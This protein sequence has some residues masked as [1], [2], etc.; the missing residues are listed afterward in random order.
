MLSKPKPLI[1]IVTPVYNGERFLRECVESVLA[2]T[3]DCWDYT[4][5]NNCSTDRTLDIAQEYAARDPRIRVQ[6]NENFVPVIENYNIAFRAISPMSKYCKPIAADDML[7]P[8]CLEK[9]VRLAEDCSS[10][11]FVGA[12]G[13]YSNAAMGVYCCGVEYPRSVLNGRELCRSYLLRQ[14]PAVFGAPSLVL[15]RSDIVRSRHRFLNESNMHADTEAYLEFL[16]HYDFGFV[17]QILT[18]K[19]VSKDSLTSISQ[20]LH[21]GLPDRLYSLKKYGPKYLNETEL[22]HQIQDCLRDYYVYLGWQLTKLRSRDFWS[23]H[24]E[25]LAALGHSLSVLR[26]LG[27]A[28]LY[29]LNLMLEPRKTAAKVGRGLRQLVRGEKRLESSTPTLSITA[30]R[31]RFWQGRV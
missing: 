5:V 30:K 20:Q 21:S 25:K 16:E 24:R 17:H 4:I 22:E 1:S 29:I 6:N 19:R 9:T 28:A 8:E 31:N 26:L 18:F 3:Y 12:Y 23:F 10:V 2:Q 27:L 11:A 13:L 7:L 14:G 15:I